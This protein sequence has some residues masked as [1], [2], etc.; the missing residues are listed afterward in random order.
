VAVKKA[1]KMRKINI[2][3]RRRLKE[4]SFGRNRIK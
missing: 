2:R 4:I 1:K 3:S